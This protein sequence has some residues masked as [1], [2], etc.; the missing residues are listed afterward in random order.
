[1]PIH[2]LPIIKYLQIIIHVTTTISFQ[3][4]MWENYTW[5]AY[6]G[7]LIATKSYFFQYLITRLS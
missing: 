7:R 3:L 6:I 1:M 5:L 2:K 4:K